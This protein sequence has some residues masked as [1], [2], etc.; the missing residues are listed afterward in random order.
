MSSCEVVLGLV[1]EKLDCPICL[2]TYTDPKLLQCFHFFC[3]QCLAKQA[4]HGSK[5]KDS[6]TCPTCRHVTPLPEGGVAGLKPAFH[7]HH[8]LEIEE[9]LKKVE[10]SGGAAPSEGGAAPSEGG[11]RGCTKE[12]GLSF[13]DA[14]EYCS[15]H[16]KEESKLYCQT[17]D[18]LACNECALMGGKHHGHEYERLHVAFQRYQEEVASSLE[19][20]KKQMTTVEKALTQLDMHRGIIEGQQAATEENIRYTFRRL[21]EILS[22]RETE[23]IGQ[24]HQMTQEKLSGLAEQRDRIETTLA[25]LSSCLRYVKDTLAP[26]NEEKKLTMKANIIREVKELTAPLQTSTLNPNTEADLVFSAKMDMFALCQDYGLVFMPGSPDPSK[27]HAKGEN[28]ALVG[29]RSTMFLHAISFGGEP[30]A[31]PIYDSLQCELKSEITGNRT[32]CR[33]DDKGKGQYEI[34]YKPAVKG[35]HQLLI[36]VAG[37]HV[38]GSPFSIAVRSPVEKLGTPIR[39]YTGV[40]GPWGVAVTQQGNLVVTEGAGHCVSVFSPSGQKLQVISTS[41]EQS[42]DPLGLAVDAEKNILVA[43][44]QDC[45][46]QKFTSNGQFLCAVGSKGRNPLQFDQPIDIAV[47]PN[48]GKIY[49][50]EST[51]HRV[52]VL[53]SDLTFSFIFG[54]RGS[55]KGQLSYPW[56]IACDSAGKSVYVA[57]TYNRRIQVFTA[58]GKFSRMFGRRDDATSKGGM[59]GDLELPIGVAVDADD[60]VYVSENR[61][62]CV[63][64]FTSE[65]H[66]LTS[67]GSWGKGPG[68]FHRPRGLAVDDSGV[69]YVC[70]YENNHIILY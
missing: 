34:S 27:C 13:E 59:R 18:E 28:S 60:R 41:Q 36:K 5:D 33:V 48:T 15:Q 22:V 7:V 49:V 37:Q 17:C 55:G 39:T 40:D 43:D 47:N 64:V 8:L 2:G 11:A 65:G 24:L 52:Q 53:N 42:K 61:T 50:V 26:G 4:T 16:H 56:G 57:D 10:T 14:V 58:E 21:R 46:L 62:D 67:F 54:R 12:G 69:V 35:R 25:Q 68:R 32:S 6:L 1:R 19:P 20:L 9:S 45:R 29:E 63:S 30:C 38:R 3:Q 31:R 66:F 51:N 44:F 23:L 70:D